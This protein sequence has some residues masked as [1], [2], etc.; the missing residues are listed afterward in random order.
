[1]RLLRKL[2]ATA[3]TTAALSA[4]F[5][6]A[7]APASAAGGTAPACIERYVNNDQDGFSVGL[8]NYCGKTMRV[9][10]IVDYAPDGPCYTIAKDGYKHYRYDGILGL[11]SRTAVC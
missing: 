8:Y 5:T 9:Q 11:Y 2:A 7:A 1:M 4:A 10:V 6:V 3:A